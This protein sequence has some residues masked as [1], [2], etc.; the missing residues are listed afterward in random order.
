MKK[1]LTILYL[2]F[3]MGAFDAQANLISNPGFE[4]GNGGDTL[5]SGWQSSGN[6]AIRNIDPSPYE[7]NN[8]IYGW[9]TPQFA[10][11][12]DID[13]LG[14]GFSS[15]AIDTGNLDIVF[16]GWQ[17]GWSNNDEGQI[18]IYLFDASMTGIGVTSLL[19]F[20]SDHLW[21]EQSGTTD[22]L[23]GT[24]YI[25]YQ[26]TGTRIGETTNSVPPKT[27]INND[28]YLDAAY[29]QIVPVPAAVWLFGSGLIG[30][31]GLARRKAQA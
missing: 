17:S 12:Q 15:S 18:S 23:S 10:I 28:A 8:Y 1:Q 27:N 16:G 13:L 6:A 19:A 30:L 21:I 9:K 5:I 7:G 4:I 26:F 3:A 29:L 2:V 31:I 25:R 24:R 14:S 22:L 11:W 20:T